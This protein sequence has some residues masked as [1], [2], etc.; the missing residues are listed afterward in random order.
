[1][2]NQ[3]IGLQIE[4]GL[5]DS[6]VTVR[7]VSSM[8]QSLPITATYYEDDEQDEC[9]NPGYYTLKTYYT[10]P[11]IRDFF[12]HY[13]PDIRLTFFNPYGRRLGCATTGTVAMHHQADTRAMHGLIALGISVL[14][15]CFVFA[16]LLFLSYRR[17][18]RLEHLT[19]RRRQS[20]HYFRTLPTGQV[21]PL[22]AGTK[23]NHQFHTQGPA[24]TGLR[25]SSSNAMNISNPSYNEPQIPT[26]PII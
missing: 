17:K 10:V 7:N 18:K 22:P 16:A 19:E 13:T 21:V 4:S 12:F 15:F 8:C 2:E 6:F 23:T 14:A 5:Y 9:P 20:Y 25:D 1:M 24:T 3:V 11:S 26:R